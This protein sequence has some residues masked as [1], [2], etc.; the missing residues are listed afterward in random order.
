MK[1]SS[2][3]ES[4]STAMKKNILL[5]LSAL[6][7]LIVI[8]SYST[9][10]ANTGG[11]NCTG[12]YGSQDN[13]TGSNCH[14]ANTGDV[15]LNLIIRDLHGD[16]VKSPFRYFPG[17]Y[18]DVIIYGNV[19]PVSSSYPKFGF[20]FSASSDNSNGGTFTP[21]T[22]LFQF[23]VG[24]AKIVEPITPLNTTAGNKFQS[25]IYYQAP[26]GGSPNPGKWKLY[27]TLLAANYDNSPFN[28]KAQNTS[29]E[30]SPIPLSVGS[31]DE[32]VSVTL[33]PNPVKDQLTVKLEDADAG[34]YTM[35]IFNTQGQILK[36]SELAV[37]GSVYS[38]TVSA[39][40]WPAGVYT[41]ELMK[42]GKRRVTSFVKQ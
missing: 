36:K 28:D 34:E 6:F 37:S 22:G 30:Y 18:Y 21:T 11:I 26:S 23:V 25:T 39:V 33:F 2:I 31:I 4:I 24:S 35:G 10:T 14:A 1:F 9:G 7:C 20:Q 15:N 38:T 3:I 42:D 13:C 19:S 32:K 16:T 29:V 41:L 17:A 40:E 27:V 12:S 8:T 5:L